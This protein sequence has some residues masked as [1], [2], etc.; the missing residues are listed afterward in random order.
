VTGQAFDDFPTKNP[1]QAVEAG[2]GDAFVTKL[3]AYPADLSGL[4]AFYPFEGNAQDACGNRDAVVQGAVL[5]TG[6]EG[7]GYDFDG[8][9]DFIQAPLNINPSQYPELTM[10]CWAKSRV[11]T[12]YGTVLS[13]D[14]GGYDRTL[15][16]DNRGGSGTA[17]S[18]FCGTGQVMGGWPVDADAWT[19]LVV[20]YDQAGGTVRFHMNGL[21][22]RIGP[23]TLGEGEDFLCMGKNPFA[24]NF[25]NGVIDNVFV[26]DR[27]LSEEQIQ[28][29]RET[30]AEGILTGK[31]SN[32]GDLPAVLHLLLH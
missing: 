16:I 6:Y 24:G 31:A 19:F 27:C 5:T 10:G 7:Q 23:G 21:A 28:F 11:S 17:W 12:P 8:S 18:A 4:V 22:Y 26:F 3:V 9:S 2:S 15:A 30:G 29:I 32:K 13:H 1:L 25:F 20:V 14:N